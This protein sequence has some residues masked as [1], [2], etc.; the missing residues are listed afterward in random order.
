[1]KSYGERLVKRKLSQ[2]NLTI[3]SPVSL[4]AVD[5]VHYDHIP[6]VPEETRTAR[7]ANGRS[8][9]SALHDLVQPTTQVVSLPQP[10]NEGESVESRES[11]ESDKNDQ[12]R[13][14]SH[15]P[16]D[17]QSSGTSRAMASSSRGDL[18]ASYSSD[19]PLFPRGNFLVLPIVSV[20]SNPP[21]QMEGATNVPVS[22]GQGVYTQAAILTGPQLTALFRPSTSPQT[23]GSRSLPNQSSGSG[24]TSVADPMTEPN[25]SR[26]SPMRSS[27]DIV[28][29]LINRGT[30]ENEGAAD[31]SGQMMNTPLVNSNCSSGENIPQS[32]TTQMN[33]RSRGTCIIPNNTGAINAASRLPVVQTSTTRTEGIR[34]SSVQPTSFSPPSIGRPVLDPQSTSSLSAPTSSSTLMNRRGVIP[35]NTG[36]INAASRPPV[37][38]LISAAHTEGIRRSSIQSTPSLSSPTLPASGP[39]VLH[40][41]STPS[42]LSPTLP[43]TRPPV[44][45]P[46]SNHSRSQRQTPVSSQHGSVQPSLPHSSKHTTPLRVI[47]TPITAFSLPPWTQIS[48]TPLPHQ[49]STPCGPTHNSQHLLDDNLTIHPIPPVGTYSS[50][51]SATNASHTDTHTLP[52]PQSAQPP[53]DTVS[54]TDPETQSTDQPVP[55][56]EA[57]AYVDRLNQLADL[58]NSQQAPTSD[59]CLVTE[60]C[61]IMNEE[62]EVLIVTMESTHFNGHLGERETVD[63]HHEDIVVD[64]T[65]LEQNVVSNGGKETRGRGRGRGR[66][67]GRGRGRKRQRDS[68]PIAGKL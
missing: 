43:A 8:S 24:S 67:S 61:K 57:N 29:K 65:L 66:G 36:A 9:D 44:L 63:Q 15:S 45:H 52:T 59:N 37:V 68:S 33:R 56:N 19:V 46:Q 26:L 47:A 5:H 6:Q 30:A 20:G 40:P 10:D 25:T 62:S 2:V 13:N 41:Q 55:T 31:N 14:P 34:R 17:T 21:L 7:I 64:L 38:P 4:E 39:P 28:S 42:L 50:L 1:M 35:S 22:S 60:D 3:T 32:S 18:L 54:I 49:D 16:V 48:D 58:L 12:R 27:L 23:S 11:R 53:T 51:P